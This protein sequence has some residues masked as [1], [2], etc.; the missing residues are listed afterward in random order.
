MSQTTRVSNV[1]MLLRILVAGHIFRD[2]SKCSSTAAMLLVSSPHLRLI[3]SAPWYMLAYVN[4]WS[5]IIQMWIKGLLIYWCLLFLLTLCCFKVRM[6]TAEVPTVHRLEQSTLRLGHGAW[7][8]AMAPESSKPSLRFDEG[9]DVACYSLFYSLLIWFYLILSL[10]LLIP[11]QDHQDHQDHQDYQGQGEYY[12]L[13]KTVTSWSMQRRVARARRGCL[14]VPACKKC[15]THSNILRNHHMSDFL[16]RY[17]RS[18][19]SSSL[20]GYA[21]KANAQSASDCIVLPKW[22]VHV[23]FF[24]AFFVAFSAEAC[25]LALKFPH[26]SVLPFKLHSFRGSGVFCFR[27][28]FGAL[29]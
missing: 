7:I 9:F 24:V 29:I 17:T 3:S 15:Q 16:T 26:V 23:A 6:L 1:S 28:C 22:P 5:K 14:S 4:Q 25:D 11:F 13:Y 18:R 10:H 8:L 12:W 2:S 21:W 19:V 20:G 27:L